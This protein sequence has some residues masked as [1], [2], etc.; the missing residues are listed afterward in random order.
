MFAR[1]RSVM[2][3]RYTRPDSPPAPRKALPRRGRNPASKPDGFSM[4]P[5]TPTTVPRAS[6]AS[7]QLV[8]AIEGNIGIGKSTLLSNLR[9]RFANNPNVVFVDEVCAEAL[10]P[11][12]SSFLLGRISCAQPVDLWEK[13]GL[14]QA[15]YTNKIDK[16]S[17]QEM[18]V[19]TRFSALTKALSSGAQL[20]I[21]E[22]S[23]FTDRE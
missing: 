4:G 17:F 14:L 22:R 23:I 13:S 9:Q 6:R 12:A 8:V 16:C 18:A 10:R 1:S 20:I 11:R 3:S 19:I 5:L 2:S 21:T 15:M 7:N